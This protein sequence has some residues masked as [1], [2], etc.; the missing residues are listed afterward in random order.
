M[1]SLRRR[2]SNNLARRN[3]PG[4][5]SNMERTL[6]GFN[7]K[8]NSKRNARH[9]R[10]RTSSKTPEIHPETFSADDVAPASEY[11]YALAQRVIG[12]PKMRRSRLANKTSA[13]WV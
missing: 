5:Q 7:N 10:S 6:K 11:S 4:Q 9:Y 12:L 13:V 1:W 2:R 8:I 3:T